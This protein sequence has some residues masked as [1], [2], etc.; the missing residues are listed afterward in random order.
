MGSSR[1]RHPSVSVQPGQVAPPTILVSVAGLTPQVITETLYCLIVK[2]KP[3]TRIQEIRVVTTRAG[4]ERVREQLF[5]PHHGWFHR[6]CRD[7]RI[8]AGSIRIDPSCI[9]V[10]RSPAGEPLEDV[11]TPGDNA[12]VADSILGLVR[13]LTRGNGTALH[14]SVA[15]GRKTM[16]LFLGIAFQLFARPQDRLSHVLVWPP[17]MEG[18]GEFFYPPL[19]PTT[20]RVKD[21]T[22]RSRDIRVELAE[23]P[24]LLLRERVQAA[25]LAA[26]PYTALVAQVQ[27]D[28]DR[29]AAPPPLI[30]DDPSRCLH[31]ADRV[32]SLTPLEF[33]VYR[34]LAHRRLNGCGKLNC[35]ACPLC[36]LELAQ[37]LDASVL[38]EIRASLVK[39]GAKDDRVRSLMGWTGPKGDPQHRF[40]EVRSRINRKIHHALGPGRWADHYLV[41]ARRVTGALSRYLIPADPRQIITG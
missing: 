5:H 4:E 38:D 10:P 27:R 39:I 33:A 2:A 18:H 6:F 20:Y 21:Q 30:L 31:I 32:V 1:A 23:I 9:L 14:C 17:E 40:L 34:V 37:F 15:G 36:S 11:R 29:L 25:G 24:V 16:G 19:R 12:L 3:P 7:F 13:D 8:P 22:I 28:L 41:T 35:P 26:L